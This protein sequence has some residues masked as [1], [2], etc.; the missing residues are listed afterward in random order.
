MSS[1]DLKNGVIVIG[2]IQFKLTSATRVY[3]PTGSSGTLQQ[4]RK[5]MKV[6]VNTVERTGSESSAISEIRIVPGD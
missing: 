4:L 1:V 2:D 3:M 6:R 5:G